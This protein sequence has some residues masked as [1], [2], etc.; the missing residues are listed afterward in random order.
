MVL[1]GVSE[2]PSGVQFES[3]SVESPDTPNSTSVACLTR[4]ET[5]SHSNV[6]SISIVTRIGRENIICR[7]VGPISNAVSIVSCLD[8]QS[9]SIVGSLCIVDS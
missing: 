3:G 9:F 8:F 2:S 4:I 6:G 7:S 1:L 5:F